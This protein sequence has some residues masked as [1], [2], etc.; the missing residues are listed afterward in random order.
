M[1]VFGCVVLWSVLPRFIVL[2]DV[3]SRV[4]VLW[5]VLPRVVVFARLPGVKLSASVSFH[6]S[7]LAVARCVVSCHVPSF[8]S[9]WI[10]E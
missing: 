2:G 4:A 6:M 9:M 7:C 8:Q 3:L 5:D 1:R 10:V